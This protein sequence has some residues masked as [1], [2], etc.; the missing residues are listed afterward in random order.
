VSNQ[1]NT[2]FFAKA[3]I[4]SY[5]AAMTHPPAF[6]SLFNDVIG[7]IMRGPSS[8]HTAGSFH[9]AVTARALLGEPVGA[10]VFTFDPDGSY[11]ETYR[12]QNADKA[13]TAGLLGWK[14]TDR[15]FGR[16]LDIARRMGLRLEFKTG[17]LP[18]ADHPNMVRIVLT[19]ESERRFEVMAKSTGGG[20]F[21][22]VEIEGQTVSIDGKKPFRKNLRMA[23]GNTRRCEAAPVYLEQAAEPIFLNASDMVAYARRGRIS[24]GTAAR[25]YESG[26]LG[27]PATWADAEME[28]RFRIMEDSVKAGLDPKKVGM[29]LLRPT[30]HKILRAEQERRLALGGI[31]VRAAA[32]ALATMHASNSGSVVC[33]APTGGSSGVLPG[34]LTTLAEDLKIPKER[35]LS[36]LFAAGAVGLVFARRATFAAE[37]AGCQVE[38]GAAGAM[39]AAAVVEAVGGTAAQA[40][41]AAAIS[42]QNSMGS[43]CD[44][45]Q[46]LCEIP[47]HTRNASAAASAFLCADL[48]LGGYR[49][50]IPLDDTIDASFSAGRMLPSELRVTSRGGLAV[51]PSA[52]GL[53]PIRR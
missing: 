29:R 38:I 3:A 49:N 15:R 21:A 16:G 51:T 31:P 39:A 44:L 12:Q 25:R 52:L 41:D 28:E 30:A 42:L 53:K 8:S 13:F 35:V 45:V 20:T 10:A 27:R 18:K 37:V 26:L 1:N 2:R 6:I 19:S 34:V 17:R 14:L 36:A 50:P 47:C 4:S 43:V 32:R 48:V 46:G 23:D 9:I 5:N 40:C 33:A 11:A 22:V 7:P 24:L